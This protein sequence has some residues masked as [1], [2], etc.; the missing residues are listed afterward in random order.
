M[1]V[2]PV[3]LQTV[4]HSRAC[5]ITTDKAGIKLLAIFG[6]LHCLTFLQKL[7]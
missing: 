3:S 4:L 7:Q 1:L 2:I 6:V 5:A